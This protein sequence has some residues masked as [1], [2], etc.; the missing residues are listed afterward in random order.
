MIFL[1]GDHMTGIGPLLLFALLQ[2]SS[3]GGTEAVERLF[4][5]GKT[6]PQFPMD[7]GSRLIGIR[8]VNHQLERATVTESYGR[9]MTHVSRGQPTNPERFGEGHDGSIDE[10]QAEVGKASIHFHRTRQLPDRRWRIGESA[11]GEILH[12]RVHRRPVGAKEIIHF[13]ENESRNVASARP[14]DGAPKEPVV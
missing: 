2:Q 7:V 12:E 4:N 8:R 13:G 5:S 11:S 6:W 3:G 9:E 14:I 10:S 1:T